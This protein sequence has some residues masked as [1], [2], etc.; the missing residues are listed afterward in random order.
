MLNV[1]TSMIILITAIMLNVW[2][3]ASWPDI[4]MTIDLLA[5]ADNMFLMIMVCSW[6]WYPFRDYDILLM[7]MISSWWYLFG[8]Y[9]ILLMISF[10]WLCCI[11][12]QSVILYQANTPHPLYQRWLD[13]TMDNGRSIVWLRHKLFVER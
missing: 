11:W 12:N 3:L 6:W 7:I 9:D 2:L 10:C 1:K 13:N 5:V 8:D 4:V